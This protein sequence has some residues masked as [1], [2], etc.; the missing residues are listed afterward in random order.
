MGSWTLFTSNRLDILLAQLN[1]RLADDPLPPLQKELILV[2]GRGIGRYVELGIARHSGIAA[3]LDLPFP[4]AWLESLCTDHETRARFDRSALL[5]RIFRLLGDPALAAEL[6]AAAAYCRGDTD[7]QKRLQL[8]TALQQ[9]FDEYQLYRPD[10]LAAFARGER[11]DLPHA[12]WQMRLFRELVR[13]CPQPGAEQAAQRLDSVRRLLRDP[14]RAARVLPP[15]LSVF[16]VASLPKAF[17]EI[18]FALTPHVDVSIYAQKPTDQWYSD[19]KRDR[20]G[21]ERLPGSGPVLLEAF[22][23]QTRQ[24]HDLLQDVAGDLDAEQMLAFHDAGTDSLLHTLQSDLLHLRD[25][26]PDGDTPPLQLLPN[27]ASLRVHSAHGPLREMEILRDQLLAAFAELPDLEPDQVLVL[28][29]DVQA[30]APYV[31]AA[32]APVQHLLRVHIA[33]RDPARELSLPSAFLQLFSLQ[34]GRFTASSLLALLEENAIARRF[35]IAPSQLPS[36]RDFV[37]RTRIRWG[38][39]GEQK[40]RDLALP[41]EDANT[42]RQGLARLVLGVATGP[43]EDPVLGILPAADDTMG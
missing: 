5:L 30:Y 2:P 24:F 13:E 16:G 10:H 4:G 32:F 28:L 37:D 20:S 34:R 33:D 35:R 27:D 40:A 8:A 29:P 31:E 21:N 41:S 18:L 11:I 25:R 15:R 17:A 6:G 39:D 3:S 36:L 19:V 42:W 1:E 26:R 12:D 43:L 22:G 38:L 9:C 14:A 23:K 7:Q